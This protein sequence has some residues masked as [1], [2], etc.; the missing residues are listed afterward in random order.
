MIND[1]LHM[2][3]W[4]VI[5]SK[6]IVLARYVKRTQVTI[7]WNMGDWWRLG[8]CLPDLWRSI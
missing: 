7:S 1:F 4:V 3:I 5:V 2:E 8:E 6:D